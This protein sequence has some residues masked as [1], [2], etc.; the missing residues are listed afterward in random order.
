M[1]TKLLAVWSVIILAGAAM[2]TGTYA[3]M[4]YWNHGARSDVELVSEPLLAVESAP[5]LKSG[6]DVI[7]AGTDPEGVIAA[8]SA[9]RNG[10]SV[11]LVDGKG[12]DRLGGLMT[13]GELNTLDLNYS[14]SQSFF[15]K[16]LG[17]YT[18]LNK[19]LFQEWYAMVEGSSFDTRTAA[20]AFYRMVKAEPNIDLLMKAQRMEP[21][22]GGA[23]GRSVTGMRIVREDGAAAEI[24]AKAV[25]D[26]TQD[27]DIAAAAG[28]PYTVGRE[29]IGSKDELMVATLVIRMSGVTPERWSKL[30]H[31]EDA[32]YDEM[33]IWGY[34]KAKDYVA[35]DPS[36]IKMRGLNI[37]RQ[38][39]GTI[40]IN[41][42]QLFGVDPLDPESVKEGMKAAQAEA[43]RIAE[44]LKQT[45][46]PF[47]ELEYAGTASELYI[48]ES[49]HII[50]E[51]RLKLT[52]LLE[53]RDHWDSIAY[54][55]YPIDIQST[56]KGGMGTILMKPEQYGVPF[57][58]LVPKEID[59]LL[60]VGRAASFDT[61]PHGSARVI[62]LGMATAE[63]A[64]AAAKL[65]IEEGVTF[66]EL[67][68]SELS[69]QKLKQM[70]KNQGMD[71][72]MQRIGKQ[73][74]QEHPDYNGL[75][76]A[77]SMYLASGGYDNDSWKLDEPSNAGRYLNQLRQVKKLH[78][79]EL[80]GDPALPVA[81]IGEPV[82]EPL[83][84]SLATSMMAS[85]CGL[86]T[87]KEEAVSELT[88]RG[89]LTEQTIDS[90]GDPE[91]LTN[92]EAYLLIYDMA[93]S[94]L[95]MTF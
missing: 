92:G 56:N 73:P 49:R 47:A 24:A 89:W 25:I 20:N 61:I 34:N 70:L 78:A 79:D 8:V 28:A 64:G 46:E 45:F 81:S 60:V 10:L 91:R 21:I 12:R 62:P 53:N 1:R 88:S 77:A 30:A 68:K 26:A 76:A 82:K 74:Y 52:D 55:S 83:S 54:G 75:V 40:L 90:I 67:S 58:T 86:D 4:W 39:D 59:G 72:K 42:M 84:L 41:S 9:A 3:A 65:A 14:P 27:G 48:R 35:S 11:L 19:G 22:V 43:P 38:A 32:D 2:L 93:V 85:L 95:G 36:R 69:I 23:S 37:G 13:V 57:R 94:K 80:P 33:S 15:R 87:D 5:T 29:D 17:R 51:Y 44:Y 31:Y 18:Y 7:V 66:R 63:A 6:Y 50:G 71:L 16:L